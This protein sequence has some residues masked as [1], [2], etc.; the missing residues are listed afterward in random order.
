MCVGSDVPNT[1]RVD[2]V[3]VHACV[4]GA[5]AAELLALN[6][7]RKANVAIFSGELFTL[8]HV[9]K[10]RGFA[11]TLAVRAPHLTLL[12][13]LESHE[14]PKEAYRQAIALMQGKGRPEGL[15]LRTTNSVPVLKALDELQLVGKIQVVTTDLFQ[16]LVTL[17]ELGKILATMY[18][19]PYRRGKIAFE[20]LVAHLL[21]EKTTQASVRLPPHGI[22]RSNLSLISSQIN[23]FHDKTASEASNT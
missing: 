18:E 2:S 14:R 19:Q 15:Y 7:T 23:T 6:L 9:E 11:A 3:A 16:E 5:I 22:F 8:D 12:P 17:I 20:N 4:S 21:K 13:A 1:E 10:L